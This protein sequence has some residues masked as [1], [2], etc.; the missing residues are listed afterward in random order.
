VTN[1]SDV[2]GRWSTSR[3]S[4]L[5]MGRFCRAGIDTDF[6][7]PYF[8]AFAIPGEALCPANRGMVVQLQARIT[9]A[10]NT[11]L[12]DMDFVLLHNPS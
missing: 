5:S 1:R 7:P 6:R 12:A 8:H 4:N 2:R 11:V 3:I 9:A 10:L